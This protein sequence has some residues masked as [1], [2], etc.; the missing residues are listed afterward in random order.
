LLRGATKNVRKHNFFADG[1]VFLGKYSST[2]RNIEICRVVDMA[3]ER[4]VH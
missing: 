2:L 3:Y 4:N 1:S